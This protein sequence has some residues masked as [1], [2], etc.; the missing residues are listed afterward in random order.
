MTRKHSE[1][2]DR[3]SRHSARLLNKLGNHAFAGNVNLTNN[4]I[5]QNNGIALI[6]PIPVHSNQFHAENNTFYRKTYK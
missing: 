4:V 1:H 6:F 2:K 3:Q 5:L